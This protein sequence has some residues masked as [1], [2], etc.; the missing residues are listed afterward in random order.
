[1]GHELDFNIDMILSLLSC[2]SL[3]CVA[4]MIFTDKRLQGHPNMLI[5]YICLFNSFNYFNFLMR[6]V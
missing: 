5:A 3:A 1:M 4:L 6:Y 2:L